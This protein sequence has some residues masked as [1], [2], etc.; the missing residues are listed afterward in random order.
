MRTWFLDLFYRSAAIVLRF[1][2]DTL[3]MVSYGVRRI[4]K[5]EA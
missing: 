1:T 2:A 4:K 3:E 5:R